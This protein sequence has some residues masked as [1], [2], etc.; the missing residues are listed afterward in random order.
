MKT[1]KMGGKTNLT[2]FAMGLARAAGLGSGFQLV[3]REIRMLAVLGFLSK[4]LIAQRTFNVCD[5]NI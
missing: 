5:T 3:S 4:S 2:C 1:I